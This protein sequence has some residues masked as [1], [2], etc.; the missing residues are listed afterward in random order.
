MVPAFLS[1]RCPRS[2]PHRP[3]FFLVSVLLPLP[4]TSVS[5]R[6]SPFPGWLPFRALPPLSLCPSPL[7]NF[8]STFHFKC[9]QITEHHVLYLQI[10]LV[11][12]LDLYSLVWHDHQPSRYFKGEC[13]HYFMKALYESVAE[14][15]RFDMARRSGRSCRLVAGDGSSQYS[16]PPAGTSHLLPSGRFR[17]NSAHASTVADGFCEH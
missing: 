6:L 11:I 17:P 4:S 3:S 5:S 13:F 15:S 1:S 9:Y 10:M 14:S 16:V 2:P 8:I 12:P 7:H